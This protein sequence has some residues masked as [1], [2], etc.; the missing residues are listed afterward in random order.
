MPV[1]VGPDRAGEWLAEGDVPV[2]LLRPYP[3]ADMR[4]VPRQH[5]WHRFEVVI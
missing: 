4:A 5:L 3:A 2:D 1:I